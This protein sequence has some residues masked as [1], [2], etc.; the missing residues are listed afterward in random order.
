M[1]SHRPVPSSVAVRG[2]GTLQQKGNRA[3][4]PVMEIEKKSQVLSPRETLFEVARK[5]LAEHGPCEVEIR[6]G[7]LQ[8]LDR[9]DKLLEIRA[10]S[11]ADDVKLRLKM[12]EG[13]WSLGL[14]MERAE[15]REQHGSED[16]FFKKLRGSIERAHKEGHIQRLP[17]LPGFDIHGAVLP[18]APPESATATRGHTL[19]EERR[20]V[21]ARVS[22]LLDSAKS[23]IKS[24]GREKY[25]S[26]PGA[27]NDEH[28]FALRD[29]T[30]VFRRHL[31]DRNAITI[32]LLS[33][34]QLYSGL[35]GPSVTISAEKCSYEG[36]HDPAAADDERL[37]LNTLYDWLRAIAPKD[38]GRS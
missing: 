33:D 22:N 23:L 1:R 20:A 3:D 4:D 18:P 15:I 21:L 7:Y 28:S 10:I 32:E 34:R 5:V 14:G 38:S 13:Q 16:A 36:S 35:V 12:G 26:L 2:D 8:I 25:G 24:E 6:G 11:S 9:G 37:A 17:E 19:V 31:S 27:P 30:L 29:Y